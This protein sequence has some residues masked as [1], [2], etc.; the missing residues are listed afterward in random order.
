M[1]RRKTLEEWQI[2]SDK[3]HN[4]E[5]E[6][7]DTPISGQQIV[8]VFHKKCGNILN[9]NLNNHTKR[10]CKFCSKKHKR[11]LDEYQK[12]SDEIHNNEFII[13]DKPNSIKENVNILHKKC[14]KIIKMTMN[15]HLNHKNGCLSCGKY[16][17][18]D[19]DYWIQ[20]SFEI[21]GDDFS[22]MDFVENV[23]KK[24]NIKH[25]IC[26]KIHKKNMN[27]FIHGKRG[28]PYCN[29]DLKY[30]EK[31]IERYLKSKSIIYEKEKTFDD[32]IN[33]K[34]GRKLRY[35]FYLP[36][37]NIVIEVNGVQHYKPILHWGGQSGYEDQV[38]RD[39]I[40]E[41]YLVDK[42]IKLVI[43]NNKKLSIIKDIL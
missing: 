39:R 3:I 21:W 8:R 5:F 1:S 24:V 22:I 12:C 20:K 16:A 35:D 7:L 13:L 37:K 36:E 27:S 34:T 14:N 38:Y 17:R 25:N 15:N 11:S 43:I 26:N 31:Y 40:K 2:E 10:Y 32:L 28:C 6:I 19:N 23:N 4:S 30:S 29:E 41:D 18:K 33:P 9:T 42:K